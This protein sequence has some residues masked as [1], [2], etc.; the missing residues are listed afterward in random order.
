MSRSRIVRAAAIS[1]ALSLSLTACGQ[2]P[3]VHVEGGGGQVF[4]GGGVAQPGG[5]DDGGFTTDPGST[6]GGVTTDGGTTDGGVT[7]DGGTTDGGVTTDGGTTDGGT[8]SGGTTSGGTSSGGSTSGGTTSGG[9]TSGGSSSGGSTGGAKATPKGSD[10]TGAGANK[11]VLGIHAPVTG[12]APLPSTSFEQAGPTYWEY[13][14]KDLGETVLGRKEVEVIFRDD[15]YDPTSARQV[16]REMEAETFLGVGGGGTDQ[17]QACGQFAE[18][19]K[20]PYFS[21]GVTE[22][23]LANSWYFASSMTYKQQ[24]ELLA[25]W[26]KKM[27]PGK[28]TAAIITDTPN[29]DDAKQGWEAAVA[30][31][32]LNYYKTL[33]HPKGDTSWYSSYVNDMQSNG[34]EVLFFLSSPVDYI[35]FAQKGTENGYKPQYIGVGISKGL[36]AVLNSG[37]EHV[38]GGQFL[39]PFPGLDYARKNIPEFFTAS[40]KHGRPADDIALALWG[41]NKSAHQMFKA[42]GNT[43]GNDLTREDFRALAETLTIKTGVFADVKY[44][45]NNHF[46]GTGA[47]MLQAD[48]AAKEHKTLA[49]FASAF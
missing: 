5:V 20:W 45:P 34:V 17:I 40:Q 22:A 12:A 2:K 13:V 42:Y 32:G 14:L 30:R 4:A 27:H 15:K 7:T 48:C 35:R 41:I 49:S 46:G 24:T 6:D 28:K 37:C 9:S 31:H 16:C 10:R 39:S 8:T 21:A 25:Q 1:A 26:V 18:V 11:I 36:N 23:G 33:G 3:G 47:H 44:S 38:N 43:F 29:F 19:S